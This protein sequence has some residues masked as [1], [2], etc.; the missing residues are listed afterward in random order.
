MVQSKYWCATLN[1][2]NAE[3][4]DALKKF[5]EEQ[6]DYMVIGK[7]K[8]EEGTPHL[9]V[10]FELV[11][12]KRLTSLKRLIGNRYH[13]EK[14]K[15]TAVQAA[16]YC[17]K[18]GDFI[19]IGE[20]SDP[21]PGK[22]TDLENVRD[23]IKNGTIN[24]TISLLDN[25]RSFPAY[26]FGM[27]YLENKSPTII[28]ETP[29]VI[30]IFGPTGVGK[31]HHA[32]EFAKRICERRNWRVWRSLNSLK[33]FNGYNGQELAIFDDFRFDGRRNDFAKLL[34]LT[35]R[36]MYSVEI[37]GG[38]VNWCPRTI[39]FTAPSSPETIFAD[40][41]EDV[42]QFNRRLGDHVYNFGSDGIRKF[43]SL[44][45]TY[46]V[47]VE[48][49]KEENDN[50]EEENKEEPEEE[51]NSQAENRLPPRKRV[52]SIVDEEDEEEEGC[53]KKHPLR[54]DDSDEESIIYTQIIKRARI[55]E[56]AL[57]IAKSEDCSSVFT[58]ESESED[59]DL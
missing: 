5:A 44:I 42:S 37:K 1:N 50:G 16:Q 54:D 55:D 40:C 39:I 49:A 10:Y 6:C 34:Q 11:K 15:G 33:W 9:Q 18:D 17:K 47:N 20:I 56:D 7:E 13:L 21:T 51:C 58:E 26:K 53:E 43:K 12:R 23:L 59:R 28:R 27:V 8:G 36:Y 52:Y 38:T 24:N 29:T 45:D 19:E 57:S 32:F 30:W 35:D 25:V 3:E 14:R 46:L 48:E 41:P 4:E 31:S 2:Y 22:R